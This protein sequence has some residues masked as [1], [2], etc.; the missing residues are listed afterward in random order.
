M[1]STKSTNLLLTSEILLF[2][3]SG[4]RLSPQLT[5]A[6]IDAIATAIGL[7]EVADAALLA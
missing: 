5:P 7:A 6:V 2:Q 4:F 3:S 1:L